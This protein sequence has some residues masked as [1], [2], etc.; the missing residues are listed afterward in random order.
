MSCALAT[1]SISTTAACL[2]IDR[3]SPAILAQQL[4]ICCRPMLA[5]VHRPF[6]GKG[7]QSRDTAR[8]EKWSIGNSAN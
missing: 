6:P 8:E 7:A 1:E 4:G 2:A 5:W 3:E